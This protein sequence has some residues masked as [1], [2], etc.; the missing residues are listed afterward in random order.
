MTNMAEM[1]GCK[2][3]HI[4]Q[5]EQGKTNPT[6]EI[7][8]KCLEIYE[9][10]EKEKADFIALA[11]ESSSRLK[12]EMDRVTTIPKTDLAKLMAVLLFGL[13]VPYPVTKEWDAV[14]KAVKELIDGINDRDTYTA[15]RND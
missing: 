14:A 7:L 15:L 3:N 11:L 6:P 10:P 5:I 1:L 2:Q 8:R 12:V 4:T 13:E 9:I